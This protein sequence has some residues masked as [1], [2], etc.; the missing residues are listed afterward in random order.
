LVDVATASA[1]LALVE[2][3]P[4]YKPAVAVGGARAWAIISPQFL[5]CLHVRARDMQGQTSG[6]LAVA[7]FALKEDSRCQGCGR[8]QPSWLIHSC[9]SFIHSEALPALVSGVRAMRWYQPAL[10]GGQVGSAQQTP[11]ATSDLSSV[12]LQRQVGKEQ[13]SMAQTCWSL[14]TRPPPRGFAALEESAIA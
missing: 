5:L 7:C 6:S 14:S 1:N 3:L 8:K 11:A 9:N 10:G 4:V 2:I 12:M 13:N